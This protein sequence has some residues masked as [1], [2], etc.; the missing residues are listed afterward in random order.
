[1]GAFLRELDRLVDVMASGPD[2]A[3]DA[4]VLSDPT[5]PGKAML[6]QVFPDASEFEAYR[7]SPQV[8]AFDSRVVDMVTG[9]SVS[10]WATVSGTS[11]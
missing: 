7:T 4:T 6:V 3:F 10:T 1:M 5:R 11:R 8:R 9:R 2:H